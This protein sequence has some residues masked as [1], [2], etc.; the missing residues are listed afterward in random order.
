MIVEECLQTLVL[1]VEQWKRSWLILVD[2]LI[3]CIIESLNNFN[4]LWSSNAY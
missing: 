1:L 2:L 3:V 4:K